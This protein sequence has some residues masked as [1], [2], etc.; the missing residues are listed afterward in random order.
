MEWR[1]KA[2]NLIKTLNSSNTIQ[3][4][5]IPTKI[6]KERMVI[7]SNIFHDNISKCFSESFFPDDLKRAEVIPIF[8]KDSKNLKK[9]Y[10]PGNLLSIIFKI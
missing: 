9:N 8:K 4:Y 2:L 7:M 6:I 1:S 3:K 10:R 5:N